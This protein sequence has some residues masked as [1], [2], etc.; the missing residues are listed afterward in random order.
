MFL[1]EKLEKLILQEISDLDIMSINGFSKENSKLINY[2]IKSKYLD[3]N[4][5][6]EALDTAIKNCATKSFNHTANSG[7]VYTIEDFE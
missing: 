6:D 1:K 7:K 3:T 5:I 4:K 2:L